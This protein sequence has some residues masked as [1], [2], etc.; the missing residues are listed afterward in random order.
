[1]ASKITDLIDQ[2]NK[3]FPNLI[4][5][6]DRKF[7]WSPIKN[8]VFYN[9]TDTH[10]KAFILHEVA[11]SLINHNSYKK[12]IELLIIEREAWDLAIHDLALRYK[13]D[14][15][16]EFVQTSLDSYR[17]WLHDRSTCP[18]CSSSGLQVSAD[19]YR[20]IACGQTWRVNEARNCTLR[21]Y[22]NKKTS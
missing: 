12:D 19:T 8:I 6:K 22:K 9:E 11:H 21:R 18:S 5:K 10:A 3:D 4:F 17:D 16:E 13:V 7:L 15:D 2:L 1:M 20:C 14:I